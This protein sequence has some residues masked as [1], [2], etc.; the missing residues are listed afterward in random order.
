VP[1]DDKILGSQPPAGLVKLS[2]SPIT[3]L[4]EVENLQSKNRDKDL[5]LMAE[6]GISTHMPEQ[7]QKKYLCAIYFS[8]SLR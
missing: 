4:R 5:T 1:D 7:L 6:I 2:A 8:A 3:N